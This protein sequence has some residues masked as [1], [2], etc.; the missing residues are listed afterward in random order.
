[1]TAVTQTQYAVYYVIMNK[2]NIWE[3]LRNIRDKMLNHYEQ[4]IL[5]TT[6]KSEPRRSEL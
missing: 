6:N 4:S 2:E 3:L 5:S 1:M